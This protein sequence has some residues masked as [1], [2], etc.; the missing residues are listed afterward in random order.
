MRASDSTNGGNTSDSDSDSPDAASEKDSNPISFGAESKA[1]KGTL[2]FVC[3]CVF[4]EIAV[5]IPCASTGVLG[6]APD[7]VPVQGPRERWAC[8]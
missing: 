4:P 7:F 2:A 6:N 3:H 5:D 8:G 1:P